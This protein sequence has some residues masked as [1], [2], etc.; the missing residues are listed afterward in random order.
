MGGRL[1][2]SHRQNR[3]MGP[4]GE[5]RLQMTS[6]PVGVDGPRVQLKSRHDAKV[7]GQ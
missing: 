3:G 6:L 7:D 1:G 4:E 5:A 2:N